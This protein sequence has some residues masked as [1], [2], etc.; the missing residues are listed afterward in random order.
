M[1]FDVQNEPMIASPGLA[2]DNDPSDWI[3]GRA[4]NMKKIIGDSVCLSHYYQNT[5]R[6]EADRYE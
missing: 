1:A 6:A 5:V 3:C 4:G 2:K